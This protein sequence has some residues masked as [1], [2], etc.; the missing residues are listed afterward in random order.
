[1]NS[2]KS[3]TEPNIESL[4]S[5]HPQFNS[6]DFD[7]LP[8]QNQNRLFP[9]IESMRGNQKEDSFD[10]S[11]N[12]DFCNEKVRR[13]NQ[14]L[15]NQ[16]N[17]RFISN[18]VINTSYI[19]TTESNDNEEIK[20][21]F[22]TPK[23]AENVDRN[24]AF[25]QQ[26]LNY[27]QNIFNSNNNNINSNINNNLS[28]GQNFF[29][30]LQYGKASSFCNPSD[31]YI[32]K[33]FNNNYNSNMI[34]SMFS[35]NIEKNTKEK[36]KKK[37]EI[38]DE[39]HFLIKLE[40]IINGKDRRTTLMIKNIPN[41]YNSMAFLEEINI[42][43]KGKYD[44]FYLPLD[45]KNNCNLGFAFINFIDPLHILLF[46]DTYCHK[47]WKK[48]KSDKICEL[49]Y[50]KYQG[51]SELISH[52]EK[53]SIMSSTTSESKKPMIFQIQHPLPK[54]EIPLQYNDI[55]RDYYPNS[56]TEKINNRIIIK[57]LFRK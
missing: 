15:Q 28:G 43:F 52:F 14:I 49:A 8:S 30:E 9:V 51:K 35:P 13:I 1:M 22:L 47:K 26:R 31:L 25:T 20:K 39:N 53:S 46:Y 19:S 40:D 24:W 41:K 34:S 2:R 4:I 36:K 5:H 44:F 7:S 23:H 21:N 50:A 37:N 45:Y 48:F 57:S 16:I 17:P 56:Q 32:N 27:N 29:E 3:Y 42:T 11:L 54:I 18:K 33:F 12:E 38:S 10:M 6:K 55:L